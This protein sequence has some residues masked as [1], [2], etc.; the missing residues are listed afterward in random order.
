MI[1]VLEFYEP[2]ALWMNRK[3]KIKTAFSHHG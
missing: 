3:W 2:I 1:E